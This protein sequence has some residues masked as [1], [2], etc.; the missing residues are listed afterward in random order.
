[1][2]GIMDHPMS[3]ACLTNARQI[4]L[5]FADTL[6]EQHRV[7]TVRILQQCRRRCKLCNLSVIEHHHTVRIGNRVNPMT[8]HP[9]IDLVS[10][11]AVT[12]SEG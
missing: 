8:Q 3:I 4:S 9:I 11:H 1:M 12:D 10:L 5:G 6:A 2:Q 7:Q